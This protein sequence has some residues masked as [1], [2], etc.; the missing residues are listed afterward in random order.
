MAFL[1][2]GEDPEEVEFKFEGCGECANVGKT[3]TCD[4]CDN[5]EYF[6]EIEPDGVDTMF[7]NGGA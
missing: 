6:E 5:G 7:R 1:D 4:D 3:R 2:F